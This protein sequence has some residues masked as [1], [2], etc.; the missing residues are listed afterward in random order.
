[1]RKAVLKIWY[2]THSVKEHK[3]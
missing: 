1:M 2:D 3:E